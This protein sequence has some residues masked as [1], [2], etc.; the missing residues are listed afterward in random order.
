MSPELA[1]QYPE[2]YRLQQQYDQQAEERQAARTLS[3]GTAAPAPPV[4]AP[5]APAGPPPKLEDAEHF[6]S[7]APAASGG[8]A[9]HSRQDSQVSSDGAGAGAL[10]K[11]RA[12]RVCSECT[13]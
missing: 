1:A 12:L 7:L 2:E 9:G 3:G 6:P 13:A 4:A 11:V 8:A 5:Q 10:G